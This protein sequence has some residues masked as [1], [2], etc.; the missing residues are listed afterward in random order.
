MVCRIVHII[1]EVAGS[2]KI[3]LAKQQG[4][5][6]ENPLNRPSAGTMPASK[7]GSYVKPSYLHT[8][9]VQP[10]VSSP[11]NAVSEQKEPK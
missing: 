1:R 3:G 5:D 10:G 9:Y 6:V 4:N 2:L 8:S 7:P 11:S